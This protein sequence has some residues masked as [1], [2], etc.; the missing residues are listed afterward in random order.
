MARYVDGYVLPV[1]K[2][3]LNAYRRMAHKA[4]RRVF[5]GNII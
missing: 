4:F 1:Q 2:K 5:M 3:N